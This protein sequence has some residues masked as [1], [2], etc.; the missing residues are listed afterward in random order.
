MWFTM[1]LMNNV[2][3]LPISIVA[4]QPCFGWSQQQ[5]KKCTQFTWSTFVSKYEAHE[6]CSVLRCSCN[7]SL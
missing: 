1:L 7:H 6:A 3:Q 5:R 2:W 4:N